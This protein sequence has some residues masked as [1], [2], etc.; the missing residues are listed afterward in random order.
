MMQIDL[1]FLKAQNTMFQNIKLYA[2]ACS[3]MLNVVDKNFTNINLESI[4]YY[5]HG[6]SINNKLINLHKLK[7]KHM[8]GNLV[9]KHLK[10]PATD[11]SLS[12]KPQF[13]N[14]M[15]PKIC[16]L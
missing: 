4:L 10:P 2:A 8:H 3:V 14:Y 12:E 13:E 15:W 6:A 5:Q 9:E 7:T 11:A 16:T 1:R